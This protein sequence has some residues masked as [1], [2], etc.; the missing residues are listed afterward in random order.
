M[1]KALAKK[2]ADDSPIEL[3]QVKFDTIGIP[4]IGITSLISHAWSDKAIKDI[5]DSQAHKAKG[6]K[7]ARDPQQEY[8]DSI[9]RLPNG[10]CGFPVTAFKKAAV[11]ACRAVPDIAMTEARILFHVLGELV[12]LVG[13]PNFRRDMRRL[14]S[15]VWNPVYRAEFQDWSCELTVRFHAG[16]LSREQVVNLFNL[17]GM[18]GV[19][20]WRPSAPK[21][22][23]GSHGMFGVARG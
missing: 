19:G 23:S 14:E 5:E 2:K 1:P 4:I 12:P 22:K 11:D 17:A 16:M 13:E 3:P 20:D 9:Y 18:C 21:G 7:G 15:G 10:G 6:A 8:Q